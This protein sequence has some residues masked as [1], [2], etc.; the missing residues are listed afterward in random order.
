MKLHYSKQAIVF[1]LV[2]M[3]ALIGY[4]IWS[5]YWEAI[6]LAESTSR[7]YA[8][9]IE[10]RL[11]ATFR[12]AE[13]HLAELGRDLPEA[14]LTKAAVPRYAIGIDSGL[15]L[16]RLNFPELVG[17]RV[18]D[19]NGDL[20]YASESKTTKRVNIKDRDYYRVWQEGKQDGV[21]Y[22]SAVVSIITGRPAMFIA[23]A[24][25]N[26]QGE[27]LG[28]VTAS[29]ELGYFQKMFQSLDIGKSG[30]IAVY[31]SDN[32]RSVVR[33]PAIKSDIPLELPRGTPGRDAVEAG[34]RTS[35]LAFRSIA[36]GSERIYSIHVL[37]RH[38]FFVASG[39]GLDDALAGW[40]ARSLLVGASSSL[41]L[42]LLILLTFFCRGPI[43]N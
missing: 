34:K 31:R 20:L 5:G 26:K 3:M 12:R 38:P 24:L 6:N 15:D 32:F 7:N 42:S 36:D 19:A 4:L 29:V 39:I 2:A 9:M 21:F 22:S 25:R 18:W 28:L 35:T 43:T 11:D 8:A 33:W 37:E 41:L 16:R 23:Q 40:R 27:L 13:A 14:A 30:S 1:G 10:S 17:L